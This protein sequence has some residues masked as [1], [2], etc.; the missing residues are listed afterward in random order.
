MTAAQY[1]V[2]GLPVRNPNNL[3]T[4]KWRWQDGILRN[5]AGE[6]LLSSELPPQGP[7]AVAYGR[8]LPNTSRCVLARASNR[9]GRKKD[10]F[11]SLCLGNRLLR[12]GFAGRL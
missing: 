10:R 7:D 1:R 5:P 2:R 3:H 6:F 12:S 11:E 8:D 4:S 9:R